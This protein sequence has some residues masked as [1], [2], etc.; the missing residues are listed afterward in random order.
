MALIEVVA[1]ED[2]R[3]GPLDVGSIDG[4]AIE[5][6]IVKGELKISNGSSGIFGSIEYTLAELV[7]GR[8]IKDIRIEIRVKG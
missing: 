7:D 3:S 5:L 6:K 8:D 2:T 4:E 1:V